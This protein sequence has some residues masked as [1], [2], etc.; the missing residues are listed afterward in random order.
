MISYLILNIYD[1]A[2]S[3]NVF[4]I[5]ALPLGVICGVLEFNGEVPTL[6]ELNDFGGDGPGGDIVG[7]VFV[8][9]DVGD[10]VDAVTVPAGAVV[11]LSL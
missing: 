6:V 9:A 2:F 3:L 5:F 11:L 4:Y 1:Y 8:G 10:S 7:G